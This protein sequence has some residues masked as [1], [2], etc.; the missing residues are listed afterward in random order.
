LTD[1]NIQ[2]GGAW[3][4]RGG[5][6][7]GRSDFRRLQLVCEGVEAPRKIGFGAVGPGLNLT[8]IVLVSAMDEVGYFRD[9]EATL[10]FIDSLY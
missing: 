6:T 1:L 2:R 7:G 10:P 5:D 8:T 3:A 9:A 4:K